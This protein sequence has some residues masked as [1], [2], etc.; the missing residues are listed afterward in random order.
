MSTEDLDGDTMQ[1]CN[2]HFDR[3]CLYTQFG[4]VLNLS[5]MACRWGGRCERAALAGIEDVVHGLD[6][7]WM[8][9]G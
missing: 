7:A 1:F 8:Q 3:Q 9:M 2:G 5:G 4:N 6:R